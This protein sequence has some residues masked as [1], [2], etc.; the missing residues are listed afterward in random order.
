[1]TKK[2]LM[3]KLQQ[4]DDDSELVFIGGCFHFDTHEY[5]AI[6]EVDIIPCDT[7]F[8]YGEV[9]RITLGD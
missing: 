6:S 7:D 3:H 9:T 5:T 8:G 2:E 1:M 4:V